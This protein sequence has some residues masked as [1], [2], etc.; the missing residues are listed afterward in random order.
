MAFLEIKGVKKRYGG[1]DVLKGIDISINAGDF[2]VLVGPSGCGKT[3]LLNL[4]AGLDQLSES[5]I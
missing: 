4:L 5:E 1:V 2:L 3:T